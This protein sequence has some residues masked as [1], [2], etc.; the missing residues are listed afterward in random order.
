[1]GLFAK[2]AEKSAASTKSSKPKKNT[3]WVVGD[4]EGDAVAKA[5]HELVELTAQE[6]ALAAKK[7]LQATIVLKVAKTNH[8]RDFCDLGVP[9]DTPMLVQNSDGEKVTFIVQDRGGQYNV[10]PEQI[11][12]MQQ[13]L[14]ED[15]AND[16]LY[17]ETTLGFDRTILGIPGV[18]EAIEKALERVV[19]KLVKDEKL[20]P[21]QAD[22]LITAK[23]KTS[24]KPGTLDRAATIVGRD[25]TKLAAFLDA[26]G[27]SC[28]R[29]IKS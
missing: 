4:P 10:K 21:E 18:G 23:Q 2:A 19:T 3:T 20:T 11:E 14:G 26:M 27:S 17:T 9:P 5:V 7:K 13:L 8:V 29:Y 16:L 1:M 22:E 24:F 15:A 25:T 28:T 12:A 6:K